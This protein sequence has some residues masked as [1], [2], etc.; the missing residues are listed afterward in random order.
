VQWLHTVN[1][2]VFSIQVISPPFTGLLWQHNPSVRQGEYWRLLTGRFA[3]ANWEHYI[4]NTG[5]L[6]LL[7]PDI[8][9]LYGWRAFL[10]LYV[11]CGLSCALLT[12]C[13]TRLHIFRCLGTFKADHDGIA[14]DV[15][16][17]FAALPCLSS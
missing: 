13:L 3:H 12:Y 11:T 14:Y 16:P 17:V 1:F 8:E 10:A 6:R 2:L 4:C 5:A 7:G 9:E 15:S